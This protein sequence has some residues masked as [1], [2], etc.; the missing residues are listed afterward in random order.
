[1]HGQQNIKKKKKHHKLFQVLLTLAVYLI[2]ELK[3]LWDLE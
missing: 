3:L 1:M 2:N